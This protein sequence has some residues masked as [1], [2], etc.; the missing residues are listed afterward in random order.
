[1][2]IDSASREWL[3]LPEAAA[4]LGVS[5]GRLGRLLEDRFLLATR[6]DGEP[7]I[8]VDFFKGDEPLPGLRGT[9]ILLADLGVTGDEAMSWLLSEDESLGAAPV[10]TLQQGHKSTVRK[11]IQLLGL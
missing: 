11:A 1:M 7:R 10:D 8:P 6:V 5:K 3:T 9:L 2:S 4:R